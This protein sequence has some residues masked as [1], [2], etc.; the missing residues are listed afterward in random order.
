MIMLF[1]GSS[2][3]TFESRAEEATTCTIKTMC[4]VACGAGY[5]KCTGKK[6]VKGSASVTCDDERTDCCG[7]TPNG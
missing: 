5:V 6:C 2:I 4:T 7:G 1:I 3:I